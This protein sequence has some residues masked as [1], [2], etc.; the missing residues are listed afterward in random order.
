MDPLS[1]TASIITVLQLTTNLTTH[2]NGLKNATSE[3]KRVAIEASYLYGLLTSLRFRIE[4][5]KSNDPWFNQVRLL[6]TEDGPLDQ[7][8]RTLE[9]IPGKI[10][11]SGERA[12]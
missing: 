5:A 7:F 3:Q 9:K 2:I 10:N 6:G 12:D 1:I 8:R 11:V 4:E